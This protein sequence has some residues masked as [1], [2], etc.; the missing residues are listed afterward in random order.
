MN[1]QVDW[2]LL[3][4]GL[5][6]G[7]GLAWLVLAEMRRHEDDVTEG[8]RQAEARWIVDALAASGTESD[9]A[10]ILEVLRLHRTFLASVPPADSIWTDGG[11]PWV[12]DGPVE[13]RGGRA[14][15]GDA[16]GSEA[17]RGAGIRDEARPA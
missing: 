12:N 5:A 15:G 4:V 16:A 2:W 10:D 9:V 13:P 1:V 11:P 14:D 6:I 8:E 3:L 7:A 17:A